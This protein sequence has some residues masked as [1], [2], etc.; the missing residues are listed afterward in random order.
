MH[1]FRMPRFVGVSGR[2]YKKTTHIFFQD[3]YS[4]QEGSE[5]YQ[6]IDYTLTNA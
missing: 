1:K 2:I 6:Y 5:M 4:H 3:L